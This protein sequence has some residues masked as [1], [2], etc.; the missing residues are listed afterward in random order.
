MTD[1]QKQRWRSEVTRDLAAQTADAADRV[2]IQAAIAQD[3]LKALLLANGGAMIALFTF[4]GNVLARSPAVHFYF[5]LL[6]AAFSLFALGFTLTLAANV[7]AFLSQDRFYSVSIAEA[8]RLEKSL[9]DDEPLLDQS[10]AIR[11][12]VQGQRFYLI[13]LALAALAIIAFGV[14]CWLALQGVLV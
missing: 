3:G 13:G 8:H 5:P 4:V 1:D 14:G 10:A 12:M 9:R 11:G 6:R 7:I 2:K